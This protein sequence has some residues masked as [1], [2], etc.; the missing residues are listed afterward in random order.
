VIIS[1]LIKYNYRSL[2]KLCLFIAKILDAI[3]NPLVSF[4][5]ISSAVA[6]LLFYST[7]FYEEKVFYNIVNHPNSTRT[8]LKNNLIKS[9][10]IS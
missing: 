9:P 6:F 5:S 1:A 2:A 10:L 8:I 4:S 3:S 7:R